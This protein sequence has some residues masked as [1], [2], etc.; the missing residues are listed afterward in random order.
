MMTAPSASP[1]ADGAPA[2]T[3]A[4][5]YRAPEVVGS[6]TRPSG[7]WDVYSFSV[8]LVELVARRV[9]TSLELC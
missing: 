1:I 7:K 8:L 9:L 6:P 5:H 3:T 4:V 2:D